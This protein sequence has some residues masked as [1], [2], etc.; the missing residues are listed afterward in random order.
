MAGRHPCNIPV[1]HRARGW[2]GSS[3]AFTLFCLPAGLLENYPGSTR[4]W[5][6]LTE[7][8]RNLFWR[9]IVCSRGCVPPLLVSLQLLVPPVSGLSE[10]TSRVFSLGLKVWISS[11][12]LSVLP[13]PWKL[14]LQ[15]LFPLLSFLWTSSS[16]S[17]STQCSH[18]SPRQI[19]KAGTLAH[20]MRPP[21]RLWEEC[22][23]IWGWFGAALCAALTGAERLIRCLS[24]N[25][26]VN[27]ICVNE[28]GLQGMSSPVA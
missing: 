22:R 4:K 6:V 13:G 27:P 9:L 19:P 14:L 2:L 24:R 25:G 12:C 17:A 3:L 28:F 10:E 21:L 18:P 20:H 26:E 1:C 11:L 15:D 16:L 7:S 23:E 5:L 8:C